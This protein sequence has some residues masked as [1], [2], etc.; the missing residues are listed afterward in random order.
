MFEPL[1]VTAMMLVGT[2]T[3]LVAA[4]DA[5]GRADRY[6]RRIA[7]CPPTRWRSASEYV[8]WLI[9]YQADSLWAHLADDVE[10]APGLRRRLPRSNG[11][12]LSGRWATRT[13]S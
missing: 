3:G 1:G 8:G 12:D 4:Q 10:G 11:T 5:E 7:P 6:P 13:A 9:D 2:A